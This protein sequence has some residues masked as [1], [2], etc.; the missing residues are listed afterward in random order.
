MSDKLVKWAENQTVYTVTPSSC[1]K[2]IHTLAARIRELRGLLNECEQTIEEMRGDR[3]I[4]HRI[5][6]AAIT[7]LAKLREQEKADG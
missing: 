7:L 1:A 6:K 3:Y 5:E 4:P 2:K